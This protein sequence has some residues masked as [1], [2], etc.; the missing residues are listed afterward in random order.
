MSDLDL[1]AKAFDAADGDLASAKDIYAFLSGADTAVVADAAIPAEGLDT[2]DSFST[3]SAV[4]FR[5]V[6]NNRNGDGGTHWGKPYKTQRGA[7]KNRNNDAYVRTAQ[8]VE[9]AVI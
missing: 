3:V 1:R 9:Q 5:N 7:E 6:Y 2:E 4:F 8:F